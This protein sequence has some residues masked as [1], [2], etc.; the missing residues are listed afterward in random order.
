MEDVR[1]GTPEHSDKERSATVDTL[2][3]VL[4]IGPAILARLR[5]V[6]IESLEDVA[7]EDPL[8]LA[9]KI[10]VG[11]ETAFK[12]VRKAR[13]ALKMSFHRAS[14]KPVPERIL[15]NCSGL[16]KLT[17]GVEVGAITEF[18]GEFATGKTQ[19]AHQLSVNVQLPK[20]QGG[21]EGKA[22]FIDTQ[23]TFRPERL[24]DMAVPTPLCQTEVME[25][26]LW[27]YASSMNELILLVEHCLPSLI[28]P[29]NI[30]LIVIDSITNLFAAEIVKIHYR[31]P[32]G[33]LEVR[34][35]F[36]LVQE[37]FSRVLQKLQS[38]ASAHNLAVFVTNQIK[39]SGR[40]RSSPVGGHI[41]A[42]A[43]A[44]RCYLMKSPHDERVCHLVTSSQR[45]Q[46]SA[47]FKITIDGIVDSRS[48]HR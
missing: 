12:Y 1:A 22:V 41:L 25:N 39:S 29:H 16:D 18:Y 42:H 48:A 35:N 28:K 40:G 32:E 6:G 10:S 8:E 11:D 4:G 47:R 2:C 36:M 19:I 44:V 26:V 37:R 5:D 9:T 34:G 14:E 43:S 15:F 20:E 30:R 21:L 7:I 23:G 3:D 31:T 33:N 27:Q 17:G 38:L 46:G 24:E 45:P 13:E